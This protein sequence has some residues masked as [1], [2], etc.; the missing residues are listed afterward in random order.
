MT[1]ITLLKNHNNEKN[2]RLKMRRRFNAKKT[3]HSSWDGRY[4]IDLKKIKKRGRPPSIG[5]TI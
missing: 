2:D 1:T 4:P 5:V 3:L